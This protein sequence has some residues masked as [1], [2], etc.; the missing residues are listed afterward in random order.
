LASKGKSPLH[1]W[2]L[3]FLSSFRLF[4]LIVWDISW[5][6]AQLQSH[7]SS[8]GI[9]PQLN[10]VT[11]WP[12]PRS[13]SGFPRTES[14]ILSKWD[15]HQPRRGEN[16]TIQTLAPASARGGLQKEHC[17]PTPVT[18]IH[19]KGGVTSGVRRDQTEAAVVVGRGSSLTLSIAWRSCSPRLTFD[20][21][22]LMQSQGRRRE[23]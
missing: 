17:V 8:P 12:R 2:S 4:P 22:T 3:I 23:A 19:S 6:S 11:H 21:K 14:S 16:G 15:Q 20:P 9:G 7:L 18:A 10:S 13:L 1:N 5:K